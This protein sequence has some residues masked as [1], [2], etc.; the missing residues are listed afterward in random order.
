MRTKGSLPRYHLY[1]LVIAD[2]HWP[3]AN[4]RYGGKSPGKKAREVRIRLALLLY[5][6]QHDS[7]F[8]RQKLQATFGARRL[9]GLSAFSHTFSVSASFTYSSQRELSL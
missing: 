6:C 1:L 8:L 7:G 4:E 9:R 5:Y 2:Q 3:E